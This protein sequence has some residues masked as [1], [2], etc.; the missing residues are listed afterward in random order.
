MITQERLRE[1]L[2]YNPDTGVF[3]WNESVGPASAG[4]EAGTFDKDGYV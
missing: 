1:V 2:D 4:S 3:A